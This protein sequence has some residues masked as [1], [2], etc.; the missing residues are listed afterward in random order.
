MAHRKRAQ[1]IKRKE[2][3]IESKQKQN[4]KEEE[5]IYEKEW[6]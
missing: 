1:Q 2:E 4:K 3:H 5:K 6:N